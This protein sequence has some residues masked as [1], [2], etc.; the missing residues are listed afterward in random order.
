[1]G[2][3]YRLCWNKCYVIIGYAGINVNYMLE[4]RSGDWIKK[5]IVKGM[6]NN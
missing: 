5:D 3:N 4:V 6:V 2:C 1:M